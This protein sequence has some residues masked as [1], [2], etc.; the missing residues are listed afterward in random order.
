MTSDLSLPERE[1]ELTRAA[2]G[3]VEEAA[4]GA[5]RSLAIAERALED[6]L[7]YQQFARQMSRDNNGRGY[8]HPEMTECSKEGERRLRMVRAYNEMA[9]SNA[10]VA[11]E[12][13]K[14]GLWFKQIIADKG[15]AAGDAKQADADVS[16]DSPLGRLR[17]LER[18]GIAKSTYTKGKARNDQKRREGVVEGAFKVIS[19][20]GS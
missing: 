16:P 15:G 5:Q 1:A 12:M 20:Q 2:G 11:I 19:E 6:A 9:L 10:K 8:A 4:N 17:Q 13:S 18:T 7:L 3:F 14:S